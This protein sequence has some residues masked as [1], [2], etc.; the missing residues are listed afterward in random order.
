VRSIGLKCALLSE[1]SIGPR[2]S[3]STS[4]AASTGYRPSFDAWFPNLIF[5]LGRVWM[6]P[7]AKNVEHI[8][9]SLFWR[10]ATRFIAISID[11][12]LNANGFAKPVCE[13]QRL[14]RYDMNRYSGLLRR[15]LAVGLVLLFAQP[16]RASTLINPLK[17]FKRYFG[18]NLFI[19]S[20]GAGMRGT[21]RPDPTFFGQSLAKATL[22]VQIPPNAVVV[23][24]FV[25][26]QSLEKTTKPSSA[27]A[28]LRDP[29]LE[30]PTLPPMSP[31]PNPDPKTFKNNPV[32][33][34]PATI[35]GK[36]LGPVNQAPCSSNG[37]STGS[38]NGSGSLRIYRWDVLRYLKLNANNIRVPIVTFEASDS[39][40]NGGGTPL[41][42]GA[43]L[44]VVY[45]DVDRNP[46]S[47]RSGVIFD[48]AATLN[49][50]TDVIVQTINGFDQASAFDQVSGS[51]NA[52]MG[53]I[54]GDGQ[55]AT[56]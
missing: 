42:E 47:F 49:N 11:G 9:S 45:R 23:S 21:G 16:G 6:L 13:S 8:E 52:R 2:L 7:R 10:F 29:N 27:V 24:A 50:D 38:S 5:G 30:D 36:P 37:G 55:C 53:Y 54:V 20:K 28:Y 22:S 1:S 12:R 3:S 39:G 26:A 15:G 33:T 51:P 46:G 18:Y 35:Y 14:G 17:M 40:S 34:Y 44:I 48:G 31:P 32:L 4:S 25:Y 43:S 41:I 19:A 56:H